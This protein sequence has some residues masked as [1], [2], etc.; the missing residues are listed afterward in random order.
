MLMPLFADTLFS[1]A[2]MADFHSFFDIEASLIR[3]AASFDDIYA[4]LH[5]R[6]YYCC[7]HHDTPP[8]RSP[9][10][11]DFHAFAFRFAAAAS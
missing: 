7:R 2:L 11:F 1:D 5:F 6:V 8:R 4:T 10:A 3:H 9:P